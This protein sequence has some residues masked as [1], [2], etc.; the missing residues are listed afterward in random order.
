MTDESPI[1]GR[2][3]RLLFLGALLLVGLCQIQ[4]LGMGFS[5][6]DWTIAGF[7]QDRNLLTVFAPVADYPYFRPIWFAW[8]ELC[9]MLGMG[10]GLMHL[11]PLVAH[12]LGLWG[13]HRLL[14]NTPLGFFGALALIFLAGLA[15]G[16]APALSWLAAGNKA[17][18]FAAMI[19]GLVLLREVENGGVF[20]LALL[21]ATILPLG[22]SENAYMMC[23][24]YPLGLLLPGEGRKSP[25]DALIAMGVALVFC[26]GQLAMLPPPPEGMVSRAS[27][28]QAAWA[29]DP[30][31]AALAFGDNLGR[32]F[33]FGIGL[34]TNQARLGLGILLTILLLALLE[35]WRGRP[36]RGHALLWSLALYGVANLPASLFPG[37]A[38][39]HHAYLPAIGAAPV[40]LCLVLLLP[41]RAW[42]MALALVLALFFVRTIHEQG[43]WGRY[44]DHSERIYQSSID[45]LPEYP[46]G[47]PILCLNMPIEYR[48]AFALRLGHRK[49]ILAWPDFCVMTTRRSWLPPKGVSLP[50]GDQG[51]WIEYDGEKLR[52]T[53]PSVLRKREVSPR[54][55]FADTLRP[56][57]SRILQWGETLSSEEPLERLPWTSSPDVGLGLAARPPDAAT[58]QAGKTERLR[59]DKEEF[60]RPGS[61]VYAW[62]VEAQTIDWRW[63]VLG[64][65]PLSLPTTENV[66]LFH[67]TP[68]P[69]LFDVRIQDRTSG[70]PV[71]MQV[72]P[73][74]G[75][76]PAL[77]L[78]P[79]KH[80]LRIELR[81]R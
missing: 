46:E 19:W 81:L 51:I 18:V 66:G 10:G 17:F 75:L 36:Q 12:V 31:G 52:R 62:E 29:G 3:G 14:R 64:W 69:W 48:A 67:L 6:E 70:K 65:S 32:F 15:P 35:T 8:L 54:A 58:T 61:F 76:L 13:L 40:L 9:H 55:W 23:A 74:L 53:H 24:L 44:L 80:S 57:P 73:V 56:F 38:S 33:L 77:R 34:A 42:E 59:I 60:G 5:P 72:E 41:R 49:E 50:E 27:E 47:E 16:T 2:P 11:G 39:R 78:P 37:E 4:V 28:L 22:M 68:L 71:S 79:G 20:L 26:L 30:P 1:A 45:V 25:T 63:L 7:L 43:L 21:P